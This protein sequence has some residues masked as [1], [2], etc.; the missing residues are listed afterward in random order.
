MLTL[1]L[2]IYNIFDSIFSMFLFVDL[3]DLFVFSILGPGTMLIASGPEFCEE[4]RIRCVR[5]S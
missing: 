2:M 3:F 5:S 1:F 4:R